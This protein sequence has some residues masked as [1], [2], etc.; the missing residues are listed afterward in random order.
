[1]GDTDEMSAR[2]FVL[3]CVWI[4][5]STHTYK[6]LSLVSVYINISQ[7][8]FWDVWFTNGSQNGPERCVT[9]KF[10]SGRYS[11]QMVSWR[12]CGVAPGT[13]T[14]GIAFRCWHA[15]VVSRRSDR[16]GTGDRSTNLVSR[17]I[18]AGRHVCTVQNSSR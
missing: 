2:S 15:R 11:G 9:I 17:T 1:M 5:H 12:R 6:R 18:V 8:W 13:G 3:P 14:D 10:S 16:M 7:W 4:E